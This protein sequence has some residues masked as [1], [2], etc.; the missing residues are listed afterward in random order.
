MTATTTANISAGC[1]SRNSGG[2]TISGSS[3]VKVNLSL[4]RPWRCL[5]L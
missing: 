5:G 1:S 4:Y 2:D 3:K